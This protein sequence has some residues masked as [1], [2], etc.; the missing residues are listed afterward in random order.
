[1]KRISSI[2]KRGET[3]F[4]LS[5]WKYSSQVAR[6]T[7]IALPSIVSRLKTNPEERSNVS[8]EQRKKRYPA[9]ILGSG[10]P[11]FETLL[12][13]GFSPPFLISSVRSFV[14]SF[15]SKMAH[16]S[17]RREIRRLDSSNDATTT[18]TTPPVTAWSNDNAR[19]LTGGG[20]ML[21][22]LK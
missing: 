20:F 11:I 9:R 3:R 22:P 4:S 7:R 10:S 14:R 16:L 19:E 17:R 13:S 15:C 18:N 5:P 21:L 12:L 2:K 1:M 6:I 8:V